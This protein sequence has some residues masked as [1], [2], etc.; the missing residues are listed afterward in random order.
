MSG[1]ELFLLRNGSFPALRGIFDPRRTDFQS[2]LA[3]SSSS[4]S[5]NCL[6]CEASCPTLSSAS[7][8][9]L[10]HSWPKMSRD[11]QHSGPSNLHHLYV[12]DFLLCYYIIYSDIRPLFQ[13]A[14]GL[15]L[16]SKLRISASSE[17]LEPLRS[18]T[19]EEGWRF[20][21]F[22][23]RKISGQEGFKKAAPGGCPAPHSWIVGPWRATL[24]SLVPS[25]YKACHHVMLLIWPGAR[26]PIRSPVP[27][28]HLRDFHANLLDFTCTCCSRAPSRVLG[29]RPSSV[30]PKL[31]ASRV[32]GRLS[33]PRLGSKTFCGCLSAPCHLPAPS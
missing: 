20:L 28:D 10:R 19:W 23:S 17:A 33:R 2:S 18:P 25:M 15:A 12:H 22:A 30:P 5:S 21:R 9:G 4:T 29:R 26:P 24:Y 3:H 31:G 13:L 8:H 7:T 16:S 6:R 1:N 32:T 11:W 27:V 14:S